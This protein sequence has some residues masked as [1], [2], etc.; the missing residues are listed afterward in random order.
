MYLLE[1]RM[2]D[3]NYDKMTRL[4]KSEADSTMTTQYNIDVSDHQPVAVA[5]E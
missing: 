5:S 3:R 1:R 2:S 4:T